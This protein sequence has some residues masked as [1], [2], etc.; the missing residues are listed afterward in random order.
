M[1]ETIKPLSADDLEAVIAIDATIAGKS[2][3]GFFEKRLAAALKDPGD[4]VYVGLHEGCALI[5][6]VLAKLV[7]GE[8]GQ[9]D[10]KASIDA[11][12][13]AP[14]HQGRGAGHQ[15]LQ[16][17]E[18]ILTHKGVGEI[19]SQVAWS[20]PVLPGFFGHIGFALAP[21]IILTRNT[22]AILQDDETDNDDDEVLEIDHS[23]PEGDD[24]TALSHDRVL[25]RSMAEA[26]LAAI[27]KIDRK[28]TG[29]DRSAYF[30]RKQQEVLHQSGVRVS[31]IAELEG[32]VVGFIM[33][34]V[35]FGEFGRTSSEAVMDAL[36]VDP[37]Y[38]GQGV[39]QALMA[40]LMANLAILQVDNI[41]TE[42]NWND[43]GL[44]AYLDA[45]G[46]APAQTLVLNQKLIYIGKKRYSA[47]G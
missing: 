28:I 46:F 31:L 10:A 18:D 32:F 30:Q 5:G 6:Y 33:A 8:F 44:I 22:S 14:D 45:T 4:Y 12:G 11:I 36:A 29:N 38:Q 35:D 34:R 27:I 21:R 16:A 25:V 15:L 40:K 2:R 20:D 3:R 41:R 39:G 7:A 17:V 1:S 23:A 19:T 42:V 24:P 9:P 47:I 13:V 26:D 43:T 37:D